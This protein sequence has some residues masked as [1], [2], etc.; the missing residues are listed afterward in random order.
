M[1]PSSNLSS[2]HQWLKQSLPCVAGAR[3]FGNARYFIT[4]LDSPDHILSRFEEFLAALRERRTVA[5]LFV[6]HEDLCLPRTASAAEQM[7]QCARMVEALSDIP[8]ESLADGG[9][10]N[11]S[12]QLDCPVTGRSVLFDDFDA[13]AFCPQ[14]ADERDPLYDPMMATPVPCINFNSDIYAYSMFVRDTA[15][16]RYG[17]EIPDLDPAIRDTL[18]GICETLWQKF[19]VRTIRNYAALTDISLCPVHITP[20]DLQWQANH[21]DPAFAE[22]VKAPYLHDLPVLYTPRITNAW[23]EYFASGAFSLSWKDITPYGASL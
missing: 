23:R 16:K 4:T 10:L 14:S 1:I 3:E 18:F 2:L 8:A 7:L 20:G 6:L 17:K 9:K 12:I 5:G 13:V 15:L 21:Q 19:A 11:I 22:T